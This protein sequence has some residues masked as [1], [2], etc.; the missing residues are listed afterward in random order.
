MGKSLNL[1][2][3]LLNLITAKCYGGCS[4]LLNPLLVCLLINDGIRIGCL[5]TRRTTVFLVDPQKADIAS[6]K[7]IAGT[8]SHEVVHMW[9]GNITTM[10][11]RTYIL[12]PMNS[13]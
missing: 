12:Y 7:A 5:I 10:A 3:T 13:H 2:L 1:S 8:Q 9:F 4:I 11:A 6:R